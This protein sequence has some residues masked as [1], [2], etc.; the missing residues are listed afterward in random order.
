MYHTVNKCYI[1]FLTLSLDS[2][3]ILTFSFEFH[4]LAFS[5]LDLLFDSSY[6]VQDHQQ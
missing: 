2:D 6:V 3:W 1:L 4:L 5:T